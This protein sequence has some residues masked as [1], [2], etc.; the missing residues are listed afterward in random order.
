MTTSRLLSSAVLCLAQLLP[1][2]DTG[3]PIMT[4]PQVGNGPALL[5]AVAD[6]DVDGHESVFPNM[7]GVT[8]DLDKMHATA[9]TLGFTE[10]T[11]LTNP[12]ATEMGDVR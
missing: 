4:L 5:I 2:A 3:L 10:I 8:H 1:A 11:A 7:P 6:Y 9:K 12:S